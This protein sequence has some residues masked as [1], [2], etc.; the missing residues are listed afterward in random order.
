MIQHLLILFGTGL[1]VAATGYACFAVFAVLIGA[2][3]ASYP[4]HVAQY[5]NRSVVIRGSYVPAC[6]YVSMSCLVTTAGGVLRLGT[7]TLPR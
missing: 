6:S 3:R 4:T 1:S 2:R 5:A 7:G